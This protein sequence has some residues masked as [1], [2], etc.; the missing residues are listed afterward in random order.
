[1]S[2]DLVFEVWKGK[3][4]RDSQTENSWAIFSNSFFNIRNVVY[5]RNSSSYR[6]YAYVAG[7]GEGEDRITVTVDLRQ[8]GEER[9]ELWVDARD[10]RRQDD[11]G[12][13]ITLD[14]YKAL[15]AQR[16]KEKLAQYR[17]VEIVN[18]S[19][20]P[21]ANLEYKRDFDLGDLCT[22]I[23]TEI[24]I[25]TDKRITEIIETYEGGAEELTVT[26]GTDEV[27]S[28]KQLIKREV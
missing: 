4:R 23:N 2:N 5:N 12:N 14:D 16:G 24:G 18:S 13:E 26:F 9:K 6:N 8:G 22:Y 28:I 19:I 25:A 17:K 21:H 20:D 11:N 1:M 15:L 7:E 3:D 10:I 27:T